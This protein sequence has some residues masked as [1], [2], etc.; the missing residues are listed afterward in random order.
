M[1]LQFPEEVPESLLPSSVPDLDLNNLVFDEHA[2]G[3]EL[4]SDGGLGVLTEGI[5]R[6]AT[7]DIAFSH[8]RATDQD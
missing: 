7:E 3:C 2:F 1:D 6:V 5:L 4:N 8:S